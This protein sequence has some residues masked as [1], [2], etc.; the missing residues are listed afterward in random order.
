MSDP[1]KLP[2]HENG[3]IVYDAG[4]APVAFPAGMVD[5]M[6]PMAAEIARALN[7][8]PALRARI[9]ALEAALAPLVALAGV[10]RDDAEKATKG[11]W[12]FVEDHPTNAVGHVKVAD[13]FQEVAALYGPDNVGQRADGVWL[14]HPLRRANGRLIAAAPDMAA[15]ILAAA[16]AAGGRG[17]Q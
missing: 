4:G 7:E 12:R 3:G 15:A 17:V 11:P 14:D 8:A 16:D 2:V 5:A 9:A 6:Q 1:I 10:I 13:H